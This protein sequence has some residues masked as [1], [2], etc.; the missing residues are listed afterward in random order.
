MIKLEHVVLPSPEQMEFVIEGMRNPMNSWD[1]S[2]SCTCVNM[3]EDCGNY[4]TCADCHHSDEIFGNLAIGPND[5]SL[6]KK[7]A[8]AGTDHRKF[9]RMIPVMVRITAPL[10]WW[11]EFDTYK[12]GTV[13]NSCST[14]HKIT[15]KE[16]A[17]EDFSCEQLIYDRDDPMREAY[18]YKNCLNHTINGL[19]S[20]REHF[21]EL[22][23]KL[24]TP[25]IS[26]LDEREK[27]A[28]LQKQYWWQL[29]QL[30]P[31]SYNQTRNVMLNYEVLANIYPSRKN[32][33]LDE[34]QEFCKWIEKLPYHEL[35]TGPDILRK[36][37][38]IKEVR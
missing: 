1:K 27:L 34:W 3:F 28:E 38:A 30:L 5:L 37:M 20:A 9:M 25:G 23:K 21:L 7:L 16:F 6:M 22:N 31:S 2:D 13:A 24:K 19:N 26:S 29:I 8:N 14:M 35:I 33:K 18:H 32:H 4:E 15:E 10:Y 17:L 36:E 12:V 11:K